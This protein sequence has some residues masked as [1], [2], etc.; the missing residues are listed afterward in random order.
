MALERV[1][2]AAVVKAR[3]A[4]HLEAHLT[5]HREDPAYQSLAMLAIDELPDRHE[6]LDL[7][8]TIGS[9]EASY[10]NRGRQGAPA[11]ACAMPPRGPESSRGEHRRTSSP[12]PPR[13][14]AGPPARQRCRGLPRSARPDSSPPGP[15]KCA[16]S[17]PAARRAPL[18]SVKRA[19]GR[20]R[21]PRETQ[22]AFPSCLVFP[23]AGSCAVPVR[24][25]ERP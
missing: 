7:A 17:F 12:R 10:E 16:R 2:G 13:R 5:A 25:H 23:T 15:E 18:A 4:L 8:H 14:S 11:T 20:R 9:K 19:S 3:R 6:V 21:L 22:A 24:E 1:L